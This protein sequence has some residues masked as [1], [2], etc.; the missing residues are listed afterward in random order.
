MSHK[1]VMLGMPRE[2]GGANTESGHTAMLWKRRGWDVTV[3]S[4]SPEPPDNPWPIRLQNMGCHVY[5]DPRTTVHLLKD[6]ICVAFCVQAAVTNWPNIQAKGNKLVWSPAMTYHVSYEHQTFSKCPPTAIHFQSDYQKEQLWPDYEKW[7]VSQ[8]AKIY[9]AFDD[10]AFP[11]QYQTRQKRF[12]I[13]KLSRP[14]RTKWPTELFTI[15][16]ELRRKHHVRA[17][18]LAQAWCEDLEA[19]LGKPPE[20]AHCYDTNHIK[21]SDFMGECHALMCLN[22]GDIENWPR[23]GLEAMASGV[24]IVA[25]NAGGWPEML[26]EKG[27]ILVNSAGEAV[28]AFAKLADNELYRRDCAEN[29]LAR[30]HEIASADSI[31]TQWEK[32]FDN[33]A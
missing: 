29:G 30:L 16:E 22:G 14:C 6:Q 23:V 7:G 12:V 11:Y 17:E 18:L 20:W 28:Q 5:L 9:G 21:P 1:V 13:G 15:V 3:I 26:G 31:G 19:R 10:R 2:C 32:L 33:I 24:P 25:E 27:G 8:Y 4:T